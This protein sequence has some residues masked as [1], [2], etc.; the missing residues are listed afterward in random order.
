MS[1]HHK[2][3]KKSIEKMCLGRDNQSLIK[4]R[5]IARILGIDDTF[6]KRTFTYGKFI[7]GIGLFDKEGSSE[8]E[9][10]L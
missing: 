1:R 8:Y 7:F 4:F 3:S 10:E 6:N 5:C 9:M 2:K